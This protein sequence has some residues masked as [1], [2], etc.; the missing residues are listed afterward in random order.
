MVAAS[1]ARVV[2]LSFGG[3][4]QTIGVEGY[5]PAKDEGMEIDYNIV[6]P[7]Y[8]QT[9]SIPLLRGRDFTER[10][11]E[12]AP[13]VVIIN[14][15]L[16]RRYFPNGD[17]LGRRIVFPGY[18][19]VPDRYAE[20]V[21]IAKEGKYRNL[22]EAERPSF[23]V[24]FLQ[25][26][27]AGMTLHVRTLG[28]PNSALAGLRREVQAMDK[29]LPIFNVK[30]YREQFSSALYKERLATTLLSV[31]GVLALLLSAIGIY[32]VIAY[33][34]SQR[35]REIGIRMALGAQARD[36]FKMVLGQ[37]MLLTAIGILIGLIAA[38]A[39]TR[40]TTSLLYE[41][42][43]TDPLSF[44]AVTLLLAFVALLASYIPAR[45]ATKVDPM[46]ALRYE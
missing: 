9:M 22:R 31:F 36:I 21:G 8:L 15:T 25:D 35:T 14:E 3:S 10:D 1:L 28:D 41:V 44:I 18:K 32:G 24:P 7:H 4:R 30:T 33:S 20:I 43:A 2:R 6:S 27:R 40:I 37:G 23:Y 12:R 26:Y 19:D 46:I 45:R 16:A 29:D 42:S 38:F 5:E 17:A 34:I 39:V 13:S 11:D